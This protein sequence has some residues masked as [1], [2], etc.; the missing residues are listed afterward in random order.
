M[1]ITWAQFI[2]AVGLFLVWN[3]F[4]VTIIKILISREVKGFQSR[5]EAAEKTASSAEKAIATATADQK[6]A[7]STTAADLRLE[8]ERKNVC[9]Q[10]QRMEDNDKE[11]FQILRQLHGDIGTLVGEIKGLR[12]SMDIV[13]QHLLTGGK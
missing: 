7:L 9:G 4:L 12:N 5:L 6:Q 1:T 11:V 13:N 3:G 2:W 10:H 8:I